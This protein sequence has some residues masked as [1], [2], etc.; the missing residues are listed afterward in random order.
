M[1]KAVTSQRGLTR[2]AG[3]WEIT[4]YVHV[5]DAPTPRGPAALM[6][7]AE[8][9]GWFTTKRATDFV[10]ISKIE[11][12]DIIEGITGAAILE[13]PTRPDRN[14]MLGWEFTISG[15][16]GGDI[17]ADF[18]RARLCAKIEVERHGR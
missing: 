7:Q 17:G 6:G 12:S 3:E 2:D 8:L 10:G 4:M 1:M 5:V 15:E 18:E 13:R 11:L 16:P 14:G 9:R